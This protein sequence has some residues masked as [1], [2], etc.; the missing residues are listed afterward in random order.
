MLADTYYTLYMVT[1]FVL[2]MFVITNF[3]WTIF[4]QQLTRYYTYMIK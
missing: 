1:T 4:G 3:M 2:V